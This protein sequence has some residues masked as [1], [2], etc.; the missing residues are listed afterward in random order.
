VQTIRIVG[1]VDTLLRRSFRMDLEDYC[2]QNDLQLLQ[3]R[4]ERIPSCW[5][6][7]IVTGSEKKLSGLG[8]V[9]NKMESHSCDSIKMYDDSSD[10]NQ[11]ET[12]Q[13]M[14]DL[15]YDSG[16]TVVLLWG[17][18]EILAHPGEDPNDVLTELEIVVADQQ[19]ETGL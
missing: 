4:E 13:K 19:K 14:A 16:Y 17:G 1:L 12:A 8:Q 11:W 18:K 3:I 2:L 5:F 15:A 9:I 10:K 6:Y 7:I